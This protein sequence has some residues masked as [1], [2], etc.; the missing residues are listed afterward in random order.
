MWCMN[1]ETGRTHITD[2]LGND[3]VTPSQLDKE[4][5]ALCAV[6]DAA[7]DHHRSHCLLLTVNCPICQA[8]AVLDLI[9]QEKARM[10]QN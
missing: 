7:D 6:A 8:L 9:R 3:V 4:Y 2:D 1:I 10:N 5:D